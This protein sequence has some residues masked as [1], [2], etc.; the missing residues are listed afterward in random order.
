[1]CKGKS[2]KEIA[3]ALGMAEAT[4][5]LHLTEAFRKLGVSSRSQAVI[6][7]SNLP[8]TKADPPNPPT[9]QQI[10]ELFVNITF[11]DQDQSWSTRVLKFSR[12][13]LSRGQT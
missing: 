6:K 7:A 5:K 4:V 11:E 8:I 12:A 1:M 10:L 9:D 3:R 13:L 2:N